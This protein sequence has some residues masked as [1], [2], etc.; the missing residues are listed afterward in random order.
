MI[1]LHTPDEVLTPFG[2]VWGAVP[3]ALLPAAPIV[4][5]SIDE[6]PEEDDEGG[7][8]ADEV[9]ED[10]LGDDFDDEFDEDFENEVD[11]DLAAFER[12]LAGDESDLNEE[13]EANL[14]DVDDEE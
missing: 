6:E 8:E 14:D 2:F 3:P 13:A 4:T 11:E 10:E 9:F 1:A 12:E 5:A 7:I